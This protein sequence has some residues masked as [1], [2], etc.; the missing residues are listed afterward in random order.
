METIVLLVAVVAGLVALELLGMHAYRRYRAR[1]QAAFTRENVGAVYDDLQAA[2]AR[3][4]AEKRAIVLLAD[5]AR[6]A[7]RPEDGA[8]L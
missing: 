7:G 2:R 6:S 8:V 4:L 5:A 3:C 1:R